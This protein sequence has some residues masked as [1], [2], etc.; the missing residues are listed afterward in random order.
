M[1]LKR[2]WVQLALQASLLKSPRSDVIKTIVGLSI[3]FQVENHVEILRASFHCLVASS[4]VAKSDVTL[5]LE[6][7]ALHSFSGNL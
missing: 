5:I 7:V 6:R 4:V 3:E 2:H 1:T